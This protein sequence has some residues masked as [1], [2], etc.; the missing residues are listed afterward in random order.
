MI[1]LKNTLILATGFLVLFAVAEV[2]F[3]F[4]RVEVEHTRKL[5]HIGTGLLTMLFPLLLT[6]HWNV[7][8]LC[9]SFAVILIF[10]LR[11]GFLPSVNAIERES[12][13]SLCYPA[14]VYFAFLTF[15]IIRDRGISTLSPM[16]FFYLPILVMALCDPAAALIGRR[17]PLRSFQCGSGRKSVGGSA[18]FFVV[19]LVLSQVLLVFFQKNELPV[20]LVVGLPLLVAAASMLAEAFTPQGFDNISIPLVVLGC[21]WIGNLLLM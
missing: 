10:S 2:L 12:H 17:F 20:L 13:G 9:A 7:L 15:E 3:R 16:L 5:V 11:L 21:L 18:A 19:A 4:F 14:A 6:S 8:L 1:D